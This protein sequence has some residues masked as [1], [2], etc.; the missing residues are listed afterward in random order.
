MLPRVCIAQCFIERHRLCKFN[1]KVRNVQGWKVSNGKMRMSTL[2][3]KERAL[4]QTLNVKGPLVRVNLEG[5]ILLPNRS[6]WWQPPMVSTEGSRFGTNSL[7]LRPATK[8]SPKQFRISEHT[9]SPGPLALCGRQ[10]AHCTPTFPLH[11][12]LISGKP[13]L[14]LNSKSAQLP[15][16]ATENQHRTSR[17]LR[18]KCYLLSRLVLLVPELFR[19]MATA[20]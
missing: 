15:R 9:Q 16:V 7:E 17:M 19:T 18:V 4:V 5:N 14:K 13:I 12:T 10:I 20:A 3:K 1:S 8:E 2:L 11:S 6:Y